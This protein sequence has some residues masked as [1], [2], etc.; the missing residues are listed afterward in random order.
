MHSQGP[1]RMPDLYSPLPLFPLMC[2][3]S[4]AFHSKLDCV[5]EKA[6]ERYQALL[7]PAPQETGSSVPPKAAL[8][9]PDLSLNAV[10]HQL[11]RSDLAPPADPHRLGCIDLG[12]CPQAL[13]SRIG[14]DI[15]RPWGHRD[16]AC[17]N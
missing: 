10:A 5:P 7:L 13:S 2:S 8:K 1:S 9:M 4:A 6:L 16:D 12:A 17:H 14:L 11:I 3:L 15:S